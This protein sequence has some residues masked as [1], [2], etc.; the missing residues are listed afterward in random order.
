MAP[1]EL[2][3][4]A[5]GLDVAHP[6][7]V[8]LLPLSSGTNTV[9]PFSTEAMA[10]CGQFWHGE[11]LVGQHRLDDDL[12]AVA[13]GLHDLLVLDHDHQAFGVDVGDDALARLEAVEPAILVRH[14]VDGVDLARIRRAAGLM[15]SMALAA[16]SRI[17]LAV[18]AHRAFSS[19]S[20]YSGM[21]LRRATIV[22]E[23]VRAGDLDRAGA[24]VGVRILVGDDR[25]QAAMLL[26][27]DRDFAQL[28][29]DRRIALV[30]RVHGHRAVA[31]HGFGPGRGD[32]DVVAR[33][34]Q[35]TFPSSSFSTYS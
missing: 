3:R 21:S 24:E 7:E 23:V 2:A 9:S 14:Q 28:A 19:I 8:G 13:E 16:A 5:P 31:Q 29:D 27:A 30:G 32:G 15:I 18:V 33:L 26:R 4:N 25:D 10:G 11:P 17:G 22:V 1:P 6:L 34:A 12:G 35:V 20:R